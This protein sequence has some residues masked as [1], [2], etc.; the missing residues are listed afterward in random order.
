MTFF[1]ILLDGHR[2]KLAHHQTE[3][4]L[5]RPILLLHDDAFSFK[6]PLLI[7]EKVLFTSLFRDTIHLQVFEEVHPCLPCCRKIQIAISVQISND[8]LRTNSRCSVH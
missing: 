3:L 1:Y 5:W 8:K 2:M 7:E 4:L 6:W